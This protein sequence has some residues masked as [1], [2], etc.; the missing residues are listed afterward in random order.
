MLGAV[1]DPNQ[2]DSDSA[3]ATRA[4]SIELEPDVPYA[5]LVVEGPDR[6][7]RFLVDP[8]EPLP[9]HIGHAPSS[10]L[11]LSDPEVS[12]RHAALDLVGGRLRVTDLDSTNGTWVE[13]VGIVD[14]FVSSGSIVRMGQTQLKVERATTPALPR[15][16]THFGRFVG[17]SP[18]IQRLYP[19]FARLAL[20]D[21]PVV[22]EG[23]TG[24]G[25]EV[26]AEALHDN[27]PRA[28]RPYVVF[29]CTAVPAAL[30]EAELFGH[31]RGAFTGASSARRGYFEQ[32]NG[33]TL[34]IDEIGDL[35]LPL[36]SKLLRAIEKKEIRRVG[37]E[38]VTRVDVRILAA[39]RRNLDKLVQDGRFRDDLY[40]RLAVGRVELPPL[41]RRRGD[42]LLL[43]RHFWHELGGNPAD[44]T[45]DLV[46]RWEDES[47][48]GNV[49]ELR[50]AIARRIALGDLA[51]SSPLPDPILEASSERDFMREVIER[52]VPLPIARRHVLD[53]FERRYCESLLEQH[54]GNVSRAAEAAHITRRYFQKVRA[55]SGRST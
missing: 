14:A 22:I 29:D 33:G 9:M 39:T 46:A 51:L 49:R 8:S 24:T 35:E 16:G 43:A 31:E 30:M 25:K 28:S 11:R 10:A 27:G 45:A 13:D 53:E 54:G 12:R 15:E 19:L 17:A 2:W 20:S 48:T 34:L 50:N 37:G 36:Q 1:S 38:G 41:R 52:R 5:L 55:R 23:E 42:I 40:H 4:R 26:L 21:I 6:G 47:W 44:L 18:E 3:T 32:A 7:K